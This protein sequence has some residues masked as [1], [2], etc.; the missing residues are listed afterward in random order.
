MN[1]KLTTLFLVFMLLLVPSAAFAVYANDTN[2]EPATVILGNA[3]P[4]YSETVPGRY[5]IGMDSPNMALKTSGISFD[6]AVA[7]TEYATD[8]VGAWNIYI[9][10]TNDTTVGQTFRTVSNNNLLSYIHIR[11][12]N[13]SNKKMVNGTFYATIYDDT[14]CRYELEKIKFN[15]ALDTGAEKWFPLLLH[16]PI[17][18]NRTYY[19]EISS[20]TTDTGFGVKLAWSYLGETYTRGEAYINRTLAST[21]YGNAVSLIFRGYTKKVS[22]VYLPDAYSD[23]MIQGL[24]RI[25]NF[26]DSQSYGYTHVKMSDSG[27]AEI[28]DM[29]TGVADVPWVGNIDLLDSGNVQITNFSDSQTNGYVNVQD[30]TF[31]RTDLSDSETN[32]YS[33]VKKVDTGIMDIPQVDNVTSVDKVDSALVEIV[34]MPPVE[35]EDS[36]IMI[37]LENYGESLPTVIL[38]TL[39]LTDTAMELPEGAR[40]I[41]RGGDSAVVTPD[42]ELYIVPSPQNGD[43]LAVSVVAPVDVNF[44]DSSVRIPE[45]VTVIFQ[46]SGVNVVGNVSVTQTD[47]SVNVPGVVTVTTSNTDVYVANSITQ[48]NTDVYIANSITQSNTD[49]YVTNTVTVTQTDTSVGITGIISVSPADTTIVYMRGKSGDSVAVSPSGEMFVAPSSEAGDSFAVNI[50]NSSLP[51][52]V[53]NT[54]VEIVGAPSFKLTDGTTPAAGLDPK[55]S[56]IVTETIWEKNILGGTAYTGDSYMYL[57][58]SG[59][60]TWCLMGGNDTMFAEIDI[61]SVSTTSYIMYEIGNTVAFGTAINAPRNLKR[62]STNT[63]TVVFYSGTTADSVGTEITR[64]GGTKGSLTIELKPNQAYMWIITNGIGGSE[65]VYCNIKYFS[66]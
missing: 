61:K 10:V 11:A 54:G 43:S 9:P 37:S 47:T 64:G 56:F 39:A 17:E 25:M 6:A 36:T 26:T 15:A 48:S 24:M 14:G 29:N 41:G 3:E 45:P 57:A 38:N 30:T 18:S 33:H 53:Q 49:V 42:G 46:D 22:V 55:L 40:L 12:N 63:S 44:M 52:D 34:A 5:E 21:T 58:G 13:Q 20:D 8:D 28:T 51:V 50:V 66:Y 16:F 19:C 35:F 2:R 31:S 7:L 27:Y 32:G 60:E 4:D 1:N 59:V 62:S 23:T 65:T